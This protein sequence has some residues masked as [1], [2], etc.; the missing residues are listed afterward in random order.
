M[1]RR[2]AIMDTEGQPR[3]EQLTDD[4]AYRD[5]Y[6]RWSADGTLLLFARLDAEDHASLWLLPADGGVPRRVVDDLSPDP[7][8]S[9]PFWFG[10]YGHIDWAHL[11]DWWRGE[12]GLQPLATPP[13][14]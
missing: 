10:Y 7:G 8:R 3:P 11:F 6:P 14:P 9:G 2:I 1:Q 5:E 12:R 13:T 4:P